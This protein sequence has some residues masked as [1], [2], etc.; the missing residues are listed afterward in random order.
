M[1]GAVDMPAVAVLAGGL[2]TRMRPLTTTIPKAMLEVAGEPFIVHQLR[3]LRREGVK[4]VVLC[5]GYLGE[6]IADYVG[7]GASFGMDVRYSYDGVKLLGTGGALR[8][9]RSFLGPE[10]M[11][12]YGDSYLDIPF[13]PLAMHFRASGLDGLMTVFANSGAW[14]SSNV[15]YEGRRIIHYNKKEHR[16][17][18]RYIDYGL[19]ML[20]A[21]TLE[22]YPA[23]QNFDLADVYSDLVRSGRMA[24]FE[25]YTRFYEIGS[26]AGL[27]DAD[28]YLA[29]KLAQT[30]RL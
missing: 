10:F 27:V 6:M 2:S 12:I 23:S 8:K 3:L 29:S 16:S 24:G 17:D 19:T 1:T 28:A 22:N 25:V 7:D 18:M 15:V 4:R 26:S 30:V 13:A 21:K 9:A 20:K 5:V 14:D 11:I